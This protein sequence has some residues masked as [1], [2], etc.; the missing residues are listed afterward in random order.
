MLSLI[1]WHWGIEGL[2][3]AAKAVVGLGFVIFIHELGHFLVA[4]W[5]DVHVKTFSIGFG[6]A[7]PGCSWVRGE[8]TYK[9]ALFPLGGYVNMVG[10]GNEEEG[11][12]DYP[13]SFKNKSVSKR[14][15]IISAGVIMNVIFGCICF[16]VAY[17]YGVKEGAAEVAYVD[18][19]SPAWKC[20]VPD[21]GNIKQVDDILN[22]SF[23]KM[24][25]FE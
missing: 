4:K 7:L 12:E 15:A 9:L 14:M 8:T 21:G 24:C 16:I 25:Q 1:Y 5:C 2:L 10:E 11:Q 3:N 13:R 18:P 23:L 6:P 20:G 22:P 19:G 17:R